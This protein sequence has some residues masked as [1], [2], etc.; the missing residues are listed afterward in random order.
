VAGINFADEGEAHGFFDAVKMEID[1]KRMGR[2]KA[3]AAPVAAAPTMAVPAPAA[4]AP[5]AQGRPGTVNAMCGTFFMS[6]RCAAITQP[7]LHVNDP[8]CST[9]TA[10]KSPKATKSSGGGWF[11][12]KKKAGKGKITAAMIGTPTDFRCA[13]IGF[14]SVAAHSGVQSR[15]SRVLSAWRVGARPSSLPTFELARTFAYFMTS[16]SKRA[17]DFAA[18]KCGATWRCIA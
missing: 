14:S 6:S 13:L 8:C 3:G 18:V 2:Q 12:S 1:K 10:P 9:N 4:A 5:P 17:I 7:H 11:G 16:M 15:Q